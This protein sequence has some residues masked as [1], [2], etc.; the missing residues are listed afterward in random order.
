MIFPFLVAAAVAATVAGTAYTVIQGQRVAKASKRAEQLRQQQLEA[1]TRRRRREA[2]RQAQ[3]ARARA[4]ANTAAQLGTTAQQTGSAIAGQGGITGQ[5]DR[6]VG[7]LGSN[8]QIGQGLFQAN[9]QIAQA[10]GQQA[11]GQAVSGFGS[12]LINNQST[13]GRLNQ[14]LFG[15]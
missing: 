9:A 2:F 8:L 5:L 13:I 15:I 4:T 6:T 10:Q 14:T 1:E 11:L 7:A 12:F 3:I